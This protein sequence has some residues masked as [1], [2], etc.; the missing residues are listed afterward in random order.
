MRAAA[1]KCPRC[2]GRLTVVGPYRSCRL[3]RWTEYR[4]PLPPPKVGSCTGA[5]ISS[6]QRYRY[7]LFRRWSEHD[8][9]CVLWVMLNPST[10]DAD[11]D[12]ATIR[13]CIGFSRSW[14]YGQLRVV[15]LFA[16]RATNPAMLEH[17][18]F[19][20]AVG[21]ENDEWIQTQLAHASIVIAA[22]GHKGGLF[23]RDRAVQQI[24]TP[25]RDLVHHL[26]LTANGGS[27]RHPLYVRASVQPTRWSELARAP[28]RM[29]P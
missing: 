6:D 17:A 16:L 7:T 22:W 5:T 21:P 26:G 12:D 28:E 19:P 25:W 2:G 8:A 15:N 24:L 14:G 1:P 11:T 27:P 23:G 10:A 13:R 29:A 20:V 18:G 9:R 3:C 4:E